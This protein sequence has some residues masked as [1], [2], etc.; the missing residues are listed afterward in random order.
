VS[1]K[2]LNDLN[3]STCV[4]SS[5][6]QSSSDQTSNVLLL[7]RDNGCVWE[8]F[9]FYPPPDSLSQ[10]SNSVVPQYHVSLDDQLHLELPTPQFH[11]EPTNTFFLT[12]PNTTSISQSSAPLVFRG[13]FT[14]A[15]PNTEVSKATPQVSPTPTTALKSTFALTPTGQITH[16]VKPGQKRTSDQEDE[17]KITKRLRNNTAAAKYRQKKVDRID[18][19]EKALAAAS[20]EKDDLKLQL[21]KRDAEVEL[22][23]RILDEKG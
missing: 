12:E 3:S 2:P 8:D 17:A 21:A 13:D 4:A 16:M 9:E 15:I 11:L 18:S 23:K 22:L 19:L 10:A 14:T 6:L 20:K 1:E 7:N 5:L